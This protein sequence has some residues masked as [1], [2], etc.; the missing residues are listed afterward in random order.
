VLRR[1]ISEKKGAIISAVH[2]VKA[3]DWLES[4]S[5]ATS[6][7]CSRRLTEAVRMA[8]ALPIAVNPGGNSPRDNALFD[9]ST[10]P[11]VELSR[12]RRE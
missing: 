12:T 8:K 2:L 5:A 1:A 7:V 9:D 10:L 4:R 6:I 11:V 3:L